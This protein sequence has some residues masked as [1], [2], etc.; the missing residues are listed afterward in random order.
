MGIVLFGR[1][2]SCLDRPDSD[3]GVFDYLD[4][5]LST[6]LF[7]NNF[8]KFYYSLTI[9]SP[10]TISIV[11]LWKTLNRPNAPPEIL[12]VGLAGAATEPPPWLMIMSAREL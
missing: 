6:Q 12:V 9:Y 3:S 4:G 2:Y 5:L 1:R 8:N 11:S 7:F 10:I